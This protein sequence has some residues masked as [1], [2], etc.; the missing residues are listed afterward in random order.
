MIEPASDTACLS[1]NPDALLAALINLVVNARNALSK[2]PEVQ[3]EIRVS[4]VPGETVIGHQG[5]KICLVDNGPGFP[6]AIL[7][8]AQPGRIKGEGY[9][10]GLSIARSVVADMGG[11]W[12]CPTAPKV[13]PELFWNCPPHW[14]TLIMMPRKRVIVQRQFWWWTT[15]IP[16]LG[17]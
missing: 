3:G 6:D 9:G 5:W 2:V 4:V 15:A 7:A 1:G 10:L 13:A 8:G 12:T 14:Q 16:Q 11:Y 17:W